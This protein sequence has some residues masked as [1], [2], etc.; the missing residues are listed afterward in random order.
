MISHL[1]ILGY[2]DIGHYVSS[3][4]FVVLRCG[5]S[6]LSDTG[7]EVVPFNFGEKSSQKLAGSRF[8]DVTFKVYNGYVNPIYTNP[9]YEILLL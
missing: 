4:G 3:F 6:K 2:L 1:L 8:Q 9:F 7:D 5:N